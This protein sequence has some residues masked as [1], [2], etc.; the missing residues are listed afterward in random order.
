VD[1]HDPKAISAAIAKARADGSAPWLIACKTVVGY[2]AP[3]KAG[4]SS[5]HGEPLGVDEIKGAR[6][7][8]GWRAAPFE[9]PAPIL[10]AWRALGAKGKAENAAWKA[11]LAKAPDAAKAAFET[12]VATSR[13]KAIADAIAAAKAQFA[14]D[15]AKRATRVWSQLT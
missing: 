6:E 12:P 2:G 13:A 3:T 8:L 9:I 14:A 15:T 4:K 10:D 1:G 5:T 11:R 7:Q